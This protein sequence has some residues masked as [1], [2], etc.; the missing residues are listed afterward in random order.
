[1]ATG[2]HR[3]DLTLLFDN[4][5]ADLFEVRGERRPRRG[6][7]TSELRQPGRC[8]ARISR[9]RRQ[10]RGRPI[11]IST[12]GRRCWR[13]TA[14]TY[15]FALEPQQTDLAVR[16][17][18]LQQAG[19]APAGAV[20]ARPAGASPRDA[21]LDARAPTS[22]ETSNNIFNEVLC[23]SM[24][25]LNMLMTDTA[26]WPLSLC[27]NSL[28]FDHVRPRRPDHR[29]ADA[30]DRPAHRPRRAEAAGRLSGQGRRSARRCRAR[31]DP[32]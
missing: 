7:G 30:V 23:Q 6:T 20:H 11:C 9:A 24:A 10:G 2:R 25:D 14:A 5:F 18:V 28:V 15:H 16:R 27:R 13:S 17:G 29:A 21:P 32:A 8:Q 26:A 1:M 22:I 3:F 12:R 4:D 31:Q 19:R